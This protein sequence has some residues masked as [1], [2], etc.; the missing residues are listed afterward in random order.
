M[1]EFDNVEFQ[2]GNLTAVALDDSGAILAS[3]SIVSQG[4]VA[5]IVVSVDAPAAATGAD[6]SATCSTCQS[7]SI[8]TNILCDLFCVYLYYSRVF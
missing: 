8:T 1:V 5:G 6:L 3:H 4:A 2:E 7:V